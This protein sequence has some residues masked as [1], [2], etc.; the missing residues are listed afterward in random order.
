MYRAARALAANQGKNLIPGR[1][2]EGWPA[3]DHL[4]QVGG[5]FGCFGDSC[6]RFARRLPQANNRKCL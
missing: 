6:A 4:G 5:D 1:L 2:G 3:G